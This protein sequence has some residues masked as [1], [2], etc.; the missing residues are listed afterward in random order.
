M[1]IK[2]YYGYD[3]GTMNQVSACQA[4][5]GKITINTVR[6]MFSE[7]DT[8]VIAIEELENTD[9]DYIVSNEDDVERVF[10]IGED[11]FRFSQI[12]GITPRRPMEGGVISSKDI[13]AID[14]LTVMAKKLVKTPPKGQRGYCVYSV[15]ADTVDADN[16]PVL[17]HEQV[18][19][20]VLDSIGYDAKPLNEGMGI[21][22]SECA[23]T[24][25]SGI[26]ISCGCGLIN[27]AF[28][29]RGI[30]SL[31]FAIKRGG[32]WIDK[33]VS[34]S[35]NV[36]VSRVTRL[37]ESKLD[38]DNPIISK[39]KAEKRALECL[40][41]FY[42]DMIEYILKTFCKEFEKSSD[43]LE[44]GEDIPIIVSGG[45][46][47]PNG[48]IECFTKVFDENYRDIFP[49]NV[50]DIRRAKDPLA[51]VATGNL[52]YALHSKKQKEKKSK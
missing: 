15:P 12:F 47:L 36:P 41:F 42:K 35:I 13:D 30:M 21:I 39:K 52:I 6:N 9:L 28:S 7:I 33:Q 49:Y 26:G 38:L 19:S 23:D 45:T 10:I 32:D 4:T 48:F 1:D 40:V 44:I 5:E 20:K 22:F 16:P 27:V 51:A 50:S 8:D 43:A 2:H 14:I 25:F 31:A 29:Y 3:L 24:N 17:Y 34:D 37:K 11:C 18:F 46:S